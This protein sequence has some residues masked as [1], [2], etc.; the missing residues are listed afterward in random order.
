MREGKGVSFR[1]AL[2]RAKLRKRYAAKHR[3]RI[4][5]FRRAVREAR[6]R[7][8]VACG[9]LMDAFGILRGP[10]NYLTI[11]KILSA[12]RREVLRLRKK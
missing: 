3:R 9:H 6:Y 2:N 12:Y 4:A 5:F 1:P 10:K 7:G 8:D 11:I